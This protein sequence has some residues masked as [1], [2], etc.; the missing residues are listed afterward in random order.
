MKLG[1]SIKNYFAMTAIE[2]WNYELFSIFM[3]IIGYDNEDCI[4]KIY[5]RFLKDFIKENELDD[6]EKD[7]II[8]YLKR[9]GITLEE[10][11]I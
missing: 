11:N 10:V 1:N 3:K 2:S 7:I 9:I 6:Y 4:L 8:V 5:V